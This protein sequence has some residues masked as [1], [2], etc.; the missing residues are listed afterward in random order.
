MPLGIN[1][2]HNILVSSQNKWFGFQAEDN[3]VCFKFLVQLFFQHYAHNASISDCSIRVTQIF[4]YSN[5][6]TY[7]KLTAL[8]EYLNLLLEYAHIYKSLLSVTIQIS[9]R[10]SRTYLEIPA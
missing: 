8:I 1:K 6:V 3:Y 5:R 10:F 2:E 4:D 7:S 9:C